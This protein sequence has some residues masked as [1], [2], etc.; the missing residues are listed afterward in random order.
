MAT[1]V[2]LD[3]RRQLGVGLLLRFPCLAVLAAKLVLLS[4]INN[5]NNRTKVKRFPLNSGKTSQ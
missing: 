4:N 3:H 1:M 5:D 2:L